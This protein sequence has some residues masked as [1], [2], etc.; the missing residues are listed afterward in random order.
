[1]AAFG[2]VRPIIFAMAIV[3]SGCVAQ[4]E[5]PGT[6]EEAVPSDTEALAASTG[7]SHYEENL[8]RLA[9]LGTV[10]LVAYKAPVGARVELDMG[11]HLDNAQRDSVQHLQF[12]WP[13]APVDALL[14]RA[15]G[16]LSA[17]LPGTAMGGSSGGGGGVNGVP[18]AIVKVAGTTVLDRPVGLS[19]GSGDGSNSATVRLGENE[20]LLIGF[21]TCGYSQDD[22]RDDDWATARVTSEDTLERVVLQAAPFLCGV[23]FESYHDTNVLGVSVDGASASVLFPYGLTASLIS[24]GELE[25]D[26]IMP[27][28]SS[29][30]M[31]TGSADDPQTQTVTSRAGGNGGFTVR[32]AENAFQMWRVVGL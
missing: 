13:D 28:G 2:S 20:W 12:S 4:G 17:V 10:F 16:N 1:M 24:F 9:D 23:D 3:A 29:V 8:L 19:S 6:N 14:A 15:N 27:D 7:P 31:V 11:Y 21:G 25:G 30:L 22:L 18:P 32:A 26:W 5:T